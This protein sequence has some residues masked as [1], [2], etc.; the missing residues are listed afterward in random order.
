VLNKEIAR[1]ENLHWA[2]K[3]KKIPVVFTRDEA[4]KVLLH[5]QGNIGWLH[6]LYTVPDC[7]SWK[8]SQ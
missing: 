4:K 1:L 2:K 8:Q 7:A 3:T 6:L 5:L